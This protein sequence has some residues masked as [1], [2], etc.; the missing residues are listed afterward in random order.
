VCVGEKGEGVLRLVLSCSLVLFG[1]F[2]WRLVAV[3]IPFSRYVSGDHSKP[4][5]GPT[6]VGLRVNF[7]V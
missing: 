6:T 3:V 5:K 2:G 7:R 1:K 4:Q